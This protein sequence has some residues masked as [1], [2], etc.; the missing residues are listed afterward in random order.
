MARIAGRMIEDWDR[1]AERIEHGYRL[2]ATCNSCKRSSGLDL[3]E[4][5]DRFGATAI[6]SGDQ[7]S[8]FA[9]ALVCSACKSRWV[10]WAILP[11]GKQT[12]VNAYLE[13]W[14]LQARC[15]NPDPS[16]KRGSRPCGRTQYLDVAS[17]IWLLGW[18]F[19]ID[20]LAGRL[21]CPRCEK[22]RTELL[23]TIPR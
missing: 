15:Y 18:K 13:R 3:S 22:P 2:V 16:T 10:S 21:I 8:G 4:M 19:E 6:L 9:Q 23:C 1:L 20:Q 5:A 17:L 12:L 14:T 11:E 7:R